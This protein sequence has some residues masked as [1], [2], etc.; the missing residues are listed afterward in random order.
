MRILQRVLLRDLL[1]ERLLRVRE[2]VRNELR[3]LL[4]S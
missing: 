3:Y 4:A 1:C 2:W